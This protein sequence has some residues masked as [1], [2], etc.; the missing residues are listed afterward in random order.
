MKEDYVW[1]M[2]HHSLPTNA[3]AERFTFADDERITPFPDCSSNAER[4][5]LAPWF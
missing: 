1:I 4:K 2:N 3:I 5:E